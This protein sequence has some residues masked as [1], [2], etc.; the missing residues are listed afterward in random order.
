VYVGVDKVTLASYHIFADKLLQRAFYQ[1]FNFAIVATFII[2]FDDDAHDV[3][4]EDS[5][6]LIW[7]Q[8]YIAIAF[9]ANKAKAAATASNYSL[10]PFYGVVDYLFHLA[11]LREG[12]FVEHTNLINRRR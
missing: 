11:E 9:K 2:L 12:A 3:A 8:K 7:G 5:V 6:H 10:G 4:G 1:L